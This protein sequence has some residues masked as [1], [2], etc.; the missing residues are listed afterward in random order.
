MKLTDLLKRI[1]IGISSN[2]KLTVCLL[3]IFALAEIWVYMLWPKNQSLGL[4]WGLG[5]SISGFVLG[6]LFAIPKLVQT[7]TEKG[8]NREPKLKGGLTVNTNLEQI[9]DWLTKIIV[10]VTLVELKPIANQLYYLACQIGGGAEAHQT[11]TGFALISFLTPFGFLFGYLETRIVF[12]SMLAEADRRMLDTTSLD[13]EPLP[14]VIEGP[15]RLVGEAKRVA[16]QIRSMDVQEAARQE[17]SL[18][19]LAHAQLGSDDPQNA[20]K[21]LESAVK[22]SPYDAKLQQMRGIALRL[23]GRK[24]EAVQAFK[25]ARALVTPSTDPALIASI[26]NSLAFSLLYLPPPNGFIECIHICNEYLKQDP[27]GAGGAILVNLACAHGQAAADARE[28]GAAENE[29][30]FTAEA[31]KCVKQ[32][33]E[34]DPKWLPRLSS[35]FRP[36]PQQK[37]EGDDDLAIFQNDSKFEELLG[38]RWRTA[39]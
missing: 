13:E 12:S 37:A 6:F 34:I 5:L 19:T 17:I 31:L 14:S 28:K 36:S 23:V 1:M 24:D 3:A 2:I 39:Y 15:P 4:L 27:R 22:R 7:E 18:S 25:N 35:L 33:V 20:L 32:A 38:S 29:K 21:T 8:P 10:G 11:S 9:S 16:D 30:Y 26:Y